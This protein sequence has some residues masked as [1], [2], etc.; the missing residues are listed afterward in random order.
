MG[1]NCN[2]HGQSA[3]K[4]TQRNFPSLLPNLIQHLI[5]C[6]RQKKD[7]RL[8]LKR[9]RKQL[10]EQNQRTITKL[11]LRMQSLKNSK[12]KT[13]TSFVSAPQ[14]PELTPQASLKGLLSILP[15]SFSS[16]LWRLL[17]LTCEENKG[18]KHVCPPME[19]NHKV[20]DPRASLCYSQLLPGSEQNKEPGR[21]TS[22]LSQ[23]QMG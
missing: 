12:L 9:I 11:A 1:S 2:C 4:A 22:P 7:L 19:H 13:E 14:L 17:S 5:T 15:L 18:G 20:W 21:I 10:F 3:G 6:P 8:L 23:A 16:L